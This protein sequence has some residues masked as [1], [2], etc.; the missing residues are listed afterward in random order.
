M[1]VIA[2]VVIDA[3]EKSDRLDLCRRMLESI[4]NLSG[5][6]PRLWAGKHC[7]LGSAKHASSPP[8]GN[9]WGNL[10]APKVLQGELYISSRLV[11]DISDFDLSIDKTLPACDG[12]F[13]AASWDRDRKSLTIAT[14]RFGLSPIFFTQRSGC[15]LF[16]GSLHALL[17]AHD[18]LELDDAALK[19]LLTIGYP[20]GNKTIWRG[21]ERVPPASRLTIS[22][23]GLRIE[24]YWQLRFGP[25][26]Q[27]GEDEL[28]GEMDRLLHLAVSSRCA[29]NKSVGIGLS[30]GLD[31]R[32][33]AAYLSRLPCA[34]HSYTYGAPQSSD[35]G[36][37][38]MLAAELGFNHHSAELD[39]D[40]FLEDEETTLKLGAGMVDLREYHHMLA[41]RM[42][43]DCEI[44]E[45]NGCGG[46]VL[47]GGHLRET[48]LE[49]PNKEVFKRRL[50]SRICSIWPVERLNE[51]LGPTL[52]S[53]EA[54][55]KH[56]FDEVVGNI[57]EDNFADLYDHF[58]LRQRQRNYI[59]HAIGLERFSLNLRY[60]FY[61]QDLV[62]FL[63]RLP[64]K[65]RIRQRLTFRLLRTEFPGVAWI[66]RDTG[67]V[68]ILPLSLR[69]FAKWLTGKARRALQRISSGPLAD[70]LGAEWKKV[71][72]QWLRNP[73]QRL[74][75]SKILHG[76]FA[77][78]GLINIEKCKELLDEQMAG[79]GHE[80]VLF[81]IYSLARWGEIYR[82]W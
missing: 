39:V 51:L 48:L 72:R 74:F 6:S 4:C 9:R 65:A 10:S 7:A 58:D 27:A 1:S 60:P 14:D 67:E 78:T 25:P 64:V 70:I 76:P 15:F 43:M 50:L 66:P 17:E 3:Q 5:H 81:K 82:L 19:E 73:L 55:P 77:E 71:Y 29:E 21:I 30:G 56:Q 41:A 28:L 36:L 12:E 40:D 13:A 32:V 22:A 18:S 11:N 63:L 75:R 34:V 46:D 38:A 47:S 54:N 20:L 26:F 57:H 16:S 37:A 80:P 45:I 49:S 59:C 68:P 79:A 44:P 62:D 24:K 33:L 53:T 42:R 31:S 23:D 35:T 69:K 2:G 52:S 61:H 8:S